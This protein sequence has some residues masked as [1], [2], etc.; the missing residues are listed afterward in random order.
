MRLLK[1]LPNAAFVILGE[2]KNLVC[3][4]ISRSFTSIRITKTPF[5]NNPLDPK[6]LC[7]Y[8]FSPRGGGLG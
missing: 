5:Y 1:T 8:T 3:S 2:A 6:N 4:I 7:Y